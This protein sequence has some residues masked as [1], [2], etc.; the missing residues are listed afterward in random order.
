[1]SSFVVKLPTPPNGGF[2]SHLCAAA[3]VSY[4]VRE[5]VDVLPID[6]VAQQSG[7]R[8]RVVIRVAH[9]EI[10]VGGEPADIAGVKLA[11]R[12]SSLEDQVIEYSLLVQPREEKVLGNIDKGRLP[13]AGTLGRVAGQPPCG[14]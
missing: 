9:G 12:G 10:Q 6:L 11:E 14:D 13:P 5:P 3:V 8:F 4:E 1:M 2:I 7:N